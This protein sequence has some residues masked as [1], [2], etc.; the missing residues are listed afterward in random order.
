MVKEYDYSLLRGK[1]AEKGITQG[2][3]AKIL[4]MSTSAFN[5]KMNNRT[6]FSQSQIREI[7]NV[8]DIPHD[9]V[10]KYFFA[11]NVRKTV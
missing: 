2:M 11:E 3:L 6:S 1:M 4:G 9:D 10:Y 5:M 7:V 8:L